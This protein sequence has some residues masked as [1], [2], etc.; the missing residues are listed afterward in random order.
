MEFGRKLDRA[1]NEARPKIRRCG[2]GERREG[3][4]CQH[5][6]IFSNTPPDKLCIPKF[7]LRENSQSWNSISSRNEGKLPL[8]TLVEPCQIQIITGAFMEAK[9]NDYC[10]FC[11]CCFRLNFGKPGTGKSSFLSL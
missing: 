8:K 4:A 3:N 9:A 11:N 2:E 10:R 5:L 7:E 1:K 6:L